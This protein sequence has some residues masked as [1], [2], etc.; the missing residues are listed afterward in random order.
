MCAMQSE[1][2]S[3]DIVTR[4]S[5]VLK[6]VLVYAGLFVTWL[7]ISLVVLGLLFRNP[8]STVLVVATVLALVTDMVIGLWRR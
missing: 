1:P 6:A 4:Q 7:A 5:E 2:S 3:F 8:V